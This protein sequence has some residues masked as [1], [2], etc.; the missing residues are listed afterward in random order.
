MTLFE[1]FIFG[2]YITMLT[3][4]IV[5][6]QVFNVGKLTRE[7]QTVEFKEEQCVET[8]FEEPDSDDER[9]PFNPE[10][11]TYEM[12]ENPMLRHRSVEQKEVSLMEQ[13]D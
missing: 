11:E 2:L 6:I 4:V 8:E 9:P 5:A 1:F 13:V 3:S 7:M 10:T 12:T